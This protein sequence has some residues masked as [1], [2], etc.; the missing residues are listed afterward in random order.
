VA[1]RQ[2]AYLE[3]LKAS[4]DG[5]D[6]NGRSSSDIAASWLESNLMD[7]I[8]GADDGEIEEGEFSFYRPEAIKPERKR[9]AKKRRKGK[10]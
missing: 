7:A 1:M 2:E 9:P 5:D 3:L 6:G 10:E 8:N 4:L